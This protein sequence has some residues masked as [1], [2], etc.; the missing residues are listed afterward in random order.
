MSKF[1]AA[2]DLVIP[3]MTSDLESAERVTHVVKMTENE[4]KKQQVSALDRNKFS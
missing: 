4:I 1:I 2:E 3:Y